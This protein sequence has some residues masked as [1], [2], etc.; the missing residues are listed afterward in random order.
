MRVAALLLLVAMH[1]AI[2]TETIVIKG[3]RNPVDKS[4][5]KM[6]QGMELFQE[7]HARAPQAAL[8]YKVLPR[9]RDSDIHGVALYVLGNTV[10]QPVALA[11]DDTFTLGRDAKALAE[12]AVVSANRPADTM[13]WRAEIRT[14]GLPANTRRLGDLRLECQ[15]GMRAGLVSQY[16]SVLDRFFGA[17]QRPA[18]YCNQREVRYLY[19][20]E[21]P[22]FA[23]VLHHGERRQ[24]LPAARLYAGVLK[25]E[26]PQAER[27]YCDCQALL[28][29]AYTLPL[30]DKSWPDDTLVELEPMAAAAREDDPLRGYDKADLA[31]ALGQGG[32]RLRFDS[33]YEVWDYELG[34]RGES[35]IVVL[36]APSGVAAKSRTLP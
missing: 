25:G 24:V 3:L 8:R 35:E 20:A 1:G 27:R 26:T 22:L 10:K 13:T 18:D 29:R 6:V 19:F 34:A 33:G 28:D 7:L 32:K 12:D 5:R 15:V 4:Y 2:A 30:G 23:V 31:L 36:F 21:Q 17:V 14:P 11:A 9:K 16:P